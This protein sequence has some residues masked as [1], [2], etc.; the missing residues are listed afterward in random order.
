MPN[1]FSMPIQAIVYGPDFDLSKV[2]FDLKTNHVDKP[3]SA[4]WTSTFQ[5]DLR[6]IGW[7]KWNLWEDCQLLKD[8]LYKV[9]PKE[10]VRIYELNSEEDLTSCR[11]PKLDGPSSIA[12]FFGFDKERELTEGY[13]DYE[14]LAKRG[15]DGL[16]VTWD[17]ARLGHSF[18]NVDQK[19]IDLLYCFDCES[20]VWFNTN[21]IDSIELV[22]TDLRSLL[23]VEE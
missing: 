1:R 7:I 17:A 16:H 8:C 21:W 22:T 12:R 6:E 18:G 15:Y 14:A 10:G 4:L 19:T 3:K 2:K 9:V 5:D 20:T 13:I 23:G 11:L